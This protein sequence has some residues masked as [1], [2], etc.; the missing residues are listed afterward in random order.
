[1]KTFSDSRLEVGTSWPLV[2]ILILFGGA[3]LMACGETESSPMGRLDSQIVSD[4]GALD[5]TIDASQRDGSPR[6]DMRPSDAGTRL[7][8][9]PSGDASQSN[10]ASQSDD[11]NSPDGDIDAMTDMGGIE[12][13][14]AA[15][16]DA[17][18]VN[19]VSAESQ[20]EFVTWP[21]T[22]ANN[23]TGCHLPGGAAEMAGVDFVLHDPD[24]PDRESRADA[25][26]HNLER[27]M[28]V[29]RDEMGEPYILRKAL[30]QLRHGGQ[31][32][33]V[34]D[35]PGYDALVGLLAII[36]RGD[37]ADCREPVDDVP[38]YREILG[39]LELRTP[40]DTFRAFTVQTLGR[41]PT[42]A[43]IRRI[44]AGQTEPNLGV[45]NQPGN[46]MQ[47]GDRPDDGRIALVGDGQQLRTVLAMVG[48]IFGSGQAKAWVKD[49]WNDVFMFRG[50]HVQELG[51]PYEVFNPWDY[52]AR[53][54][55]DL[56]DI[57]VFETDEDGE[58]IIGPGRQPMCNL[59]YE[60]FGFT[61]VLQ[62]NA[63]GTGYGGQPVLTPVEAC[64]FCRFTRR[65][66]AEF[67]LHGAIES[68][69]ELI[70]DIIKR[71]QPFTSIVTT[72]DIMMNYYTSLVYF[73][74]A[75]PMENDF[76]ANMDNVAMLDA[77]QNGPNWVV[78]DVEL[79]DHRVFKRLDR[80]RRTQQI[81][82]PSSYPKLDENGDQVIGENGR[83]ETES[84]EERYFVYRSEHSAGQPD[85][86]PRAGILTS[87]A[88]MTRFPSN[89][90][91]LH[92]HRAWQVMRLFL[93]YDIL[94]NQG[95]RI[96]LAD[97]PDPNGGATTDPNGD[98]VG[99]HV[100]LDP[101]AGLFKDFAFGGASK[102]VAT[103][104]AQWPGDIHPPGWPAIDGDQAIEHER[105]LHG[106]P[107]RLLA[108]RIAQ[109][110]RFPRA[111]VKYAWKQV[112]GREP[113]D[114]AADPERD[115]FA[116][117]STILIAQ[118]RFFESLVASFVRTGYDMTHVYQRLITS[119][120]YRARG[121]KPAA[122][123][124]VPDSVYEGVGRHGTLTPEEYFRRIEAIYGGSWPLNAIPQSSAIAVTQEEQL[125]RDFFTRTDSHYSNF[126]K[127]IG[128]ID[129]SF[130]SFFGGIDFQNS[131][132]RASLINSVMTLMAQRVANEFACL[133]VYDDFQ[134]PPEDRRYFPLIP[135]PAGR[136]DVAN[137]AA[138]RA[139]IVHLFDL[140]LGLS[141]EADSAE[142]DIA[143]QLW[144]D[145]RQTALDEIE[146]DPRIGVLLIAHCRSHGSADRRGGLGG[147]HDPQ[148]EIR[149]WMSVI[150][151]LMLQPELLQR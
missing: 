87:P 25:F 37:D 9:S 95:E 109:S 50:I 99:C 8:V 49:M 124:D 19:C 90:F 56:C 28:A 93:D 23:C 104:D 96:S 137:E 36:E 138:V 126:D 83:P 142:A 63:A 150:S 147:N 130:S 31:Q 141:V 52:G 42:S 4:G 69:L 113:L 2:S 132:T 127:L 62:P 77:L 17:E 7:D 92:R 27:I 55:S 118:D 57:K 29:A 75:D 107:I 122:D 115:D 14:D 45:G 67:M 3:S 11:A 148:G 59:N 123:D 18:L 58:P 98:C 12:P 44:R 61:E 48:E 6:A 35:T 38:G 22:F 5:S 60:R 70:A 79:P 146:E 88:F 68:P 97:V 66:I 86:F 30:G 94:D 80:M 64:D 116:A 110:P 139:N 149:A 10:D 53:H 117:R 120:W 133:V 15:M 100:R 136:D 13:M 43:E 21:Q 106:P 135:L 46:N 85:S 71:R 81:R 103:A 78:F 65:G 112:M 40:E 145:A 131:L 41:L 108:D 140:I 54:W 84:G 151:Y 39:R 111:M 76:T 119:L 34:P 82:T 121:L 144:T 72:E 91:N 20:L 128:M 114:I 32:R 143:W 26:A 102:L 105:D 47:P 125:K 33:L 74:T 51:R 101:V 129:S 16:P 1:M 73:G 89:D 24:N 134:K